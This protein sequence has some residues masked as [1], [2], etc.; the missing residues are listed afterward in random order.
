MTTRVVLTCDACGLD[1]ELA[2]KEAPK[3]WGRLAIAGRTMDVCPRDVARLRG[4][5]D[6]IVAG[7]GLRVSG[8]FVSL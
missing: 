7:T 1:V 2:D 5:E 8:N 6:P 3:G 4:W